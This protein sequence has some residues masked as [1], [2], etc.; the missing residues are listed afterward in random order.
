MGRLNQFLL[1][2]VF[3]TRLPLGR[4]LPA[5]ILPLSQSL[6]AFPLAGMLI[7]AIAALPL[8]VMGQGLFPAALSVTLAVLLTGALHEDALADF[9][10]AAGGRTREDRLRIMRNSAIGSYGVMALILS[11][12]LRITAISQLTP[13]AVLAAAAAGRAAIVLVMAALPAARQEGLGKSAGRP[14]AGNLALA[15]IFGALPLMLLG[16]PGFLAL[17]AALIGTG[18]VIWR[19]RSWIGGQTGDVLGSASVIAEVAVLSVLA[20]VAQLAHS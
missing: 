3:L 8:W 14:D 7:G 6:W 5:T 19:A 4:L 20:M 12:A 2:L 10:D 15:L 11:T 9:T 17:I 16:F 13:V 18:W 1:A